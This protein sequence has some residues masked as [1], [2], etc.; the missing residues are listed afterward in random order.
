MQTNATGRGP[1]TPNRSAAAVFRSDPLEATTG[2][3]DDDP[4]SQDDYLPKLSQHYQ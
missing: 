1:S 4:I 2:T 3:S